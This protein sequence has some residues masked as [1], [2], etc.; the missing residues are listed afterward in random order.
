M[1]KGRDQILA[2][3]PVEALEDFEEIKVA[4]DYAFEWGTYRWTS[5]PRA[6]GDPVSSSGK[7]LRILQRDSDGSWKMY[8]TIATND[9]TRALAAVRAIE[10][11][12][13]SIKRCYAAPVF[14]SIQ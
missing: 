1:Q 11:I 4:G 2:F 13:G 6:G 3:E 7:L 9:S 5:R 12:G 14:M 10:M 8:R